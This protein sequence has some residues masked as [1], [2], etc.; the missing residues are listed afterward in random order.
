MNGYR[1]T[2]NFDDAYRVNE[3]P[4]DLSEKTIVGGSAR[5]HKGDKSVYTSEEDVIINIHNNQANI[6]ILSKIDDGQE[7]V[8]ASISINSG[9]NIQIDPEYLS[10]GVFS[11][12]TNVDNTKEYFEYHEVD[13]FVYSIED[14]QLVTD[15]EF[16]YATG[17]A[18]DAKEGAEY[19][20]LLS[21]GYEPNHDYSEY[22]RLCRLIRLSCV[23]KKGT[24]GAYTVK[25]NAQPTP[26]PDAD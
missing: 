25:I 22:L 13:P 14:G 19:A 2:A 4:Y 10:D 9:T 26:T 16:W 6:L 15:E 12:C 7:T 3:P 20:G 18:Q 11:V 24:F 21:I 23:F 1:Y 5:P 8:I 17:V